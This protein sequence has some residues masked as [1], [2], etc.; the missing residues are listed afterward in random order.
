M[1]LIRQNLTKVSTPDRFHRA[2]GKHYSLLALSLSRFLTRLCGSAGGR[3]QKGA[4]HE[5]FGNRRAF[6]TMLHF[7]NKK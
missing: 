1:K 5:H 4:E 7:V 6:P 3:T 2:S